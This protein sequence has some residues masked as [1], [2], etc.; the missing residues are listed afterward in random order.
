M[1]SGTYFPP[2]MREVVISKRDGGKRKLGIPTV[3]ANCGTVQC[4]RRSRP[5]AGS[6]MASR[7]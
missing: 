1:A 5:M 2:P 7:T 6:T 4:A 3:T